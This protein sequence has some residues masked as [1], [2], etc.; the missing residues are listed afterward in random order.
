MNGAYSEPDY[1]YAGLISRLLELPRANQVLSLRTGDGSEIQLVRESVGPLKLR[2]D[3]SCGADEAAAAHALMR[4][5]AH[6]RPDLVR[7][8]DPQDPFEGVVFTT[9]NP[10][11]ASALAYRIVTEAL[12]AD[13]AKVTVDKDY[14][15]N[16]ARPEI[17]AW[18]DYRRFIEILHEESGVRVRVKLY[19]SAGAK[20]GA[21]D[22]KPG[23]RIDVPTAPLDPRRG[24]RHRARQAI[25]EAGWRHYDGDTGPEPESEG[26]L[27]VAAGSWG[28]SVDRGDSAE[29][30][31]AALRLLCTIAEL[32]MDVQVRVFPLAKRA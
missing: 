28:Y 17:A 23:Y 32:P 12:G 2:L 31:D 3:G 10:F 22:E 21:E 27:D 9:D 1:Q 19:G 14:D 13:P 24:Q 6:F 4:V 15:D 5:E 29:A 16:D 11:S 25:S 18:L 30:A 7:L 8:L 26:W 20:A